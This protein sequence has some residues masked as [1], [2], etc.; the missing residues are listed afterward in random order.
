MAS[1]K[2]DVT[3]RK[4]VSHDDYLPSRVPPA[5]N[6]LQS[7]EHDPALVGIHPRLSAMRISKIAPSAPLARELV[8]P[9]KTGQR[10][11]FRVV[12]PLMWRTRFAALHTPVADR[13]LLASLDVEVA[14]YTSYAVSIQSV[15]L[16]MLGGDMEPLAAV[17]AATPCSPGDQLSY[18]Y[19]ATPDLGPDGTPALGSKGH[20]LTVRILADVHV[21]PLCTPRVAITWR[22]PVDFAPEHDTQERGAPS[23]AANV[24]LTMTGPCRVKVG[25][26]FHWSL[27]I[28]NRSASAQ[29]LGIIVLPK[30]K[31][32]P[33]HRPSSSAAV[34]AS[35]GASTAL[36]APAVQDSNAVYA[37]QKSARAEPAQ[38]VCLTT[39]LRL[40]PLAPGACY[41]AEVGFV[42]LAAGALA[43]ECVR[44]VD[45][46]T[47][48]VVDV[49]EVAGV[50]AVEEEEEEEV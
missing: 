34:P 17:G 31:H 1:L 13:S 8:R 9:I 47:G 29:R 23:A 30:R 50:V 4:P 10:P 18:L 19:K 6:L 46:G 11:L 26:P 42:A 16:S 27:F 41:T 24:T 3:A 33:T 25:T 32:T 40:G 7:F 36:L 49:R 39:E 37:R 22:T 5:L 44:V 28:L 14:S 35:H 21:G 38:L 15:D 43:V 12:P 20:T 48:G 2:P 45:L